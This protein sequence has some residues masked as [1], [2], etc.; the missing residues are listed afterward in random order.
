MVFQG[1]RANNPKHTE[2]IVND[3]VPLRKNGGGENGATE[4]K[5][6]YRGSWGVCKIHT[7][8]GW[9]QGALGGYQKIYEK[10]TIFRG[11]GGRAL[12]PKFLGEEFT[13]RGM[14]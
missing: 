10:R 8:N 6:T 14:E 13:E 3:C 7:G 9:D 2:K 11:G 4:L 1:E 5:Q 12:V